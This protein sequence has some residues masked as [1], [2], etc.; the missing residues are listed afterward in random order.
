MAIHT[1]CI[2][3]F[4]LIVVQNLYAK[5][6]ENTTNEQELIKKILN[7][8]PTAS[9][10]LHVFLLETM[11]IKPKQYA[12]NAF[13]ATQYLLKDPALLQNN[14]L[15][16]TF[17]KD[18]LN[19]VINT[20]KPSATEIT[21]YFETM[22]IFSNVMEY[23]YQL[24]QDKVTSDTKFIVDLINKYDCKTL[25]M[26]IKGHYEATFTEFNKKF[27]EHKKDLEQPILDWY[28]KYAALT[29]TPEKLISLLD[30][31]SLFEI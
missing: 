9:E 4:V 7:G 22:I 24:P 6:V 10:K 11:N 14:N 5:P 23:Y 17:F 29:S 21:T 31:L 25:A 8:N 27:E 16:V 30:L 26:K 2:I 20:Y 1:I 3:A 13:N 28:D 19:R 18:E 12:A 15:E